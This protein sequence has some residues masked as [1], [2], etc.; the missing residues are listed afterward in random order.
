LRIAFSATE[1][2]VCTKIAQPAARSGRQDVEKAFDGGAVVVN[3]PGLGGESRDC[4]SAP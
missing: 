2:K 1:V 3:I 4:E